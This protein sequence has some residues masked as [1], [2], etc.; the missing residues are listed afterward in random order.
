MKTILFIIFLIYSLIVLPQEISQQNIKIAA[1]NFYSFINKKKSSNIIFTKDNTYLNKHTFTIVVFED[2]N[3]IILSADKRSEPILA[4]SF[5]QN[6]TEDVPPA[7]KIILKEYDE[8]VYNQSIS[9]IKYNDNF[10]YWTDL[11]ENNLLKYNQKGVVVE[12]LI[13]TK[14]GQSKSN[15]EQDENAYNYYAPGGDECE[16]T[17]VGCPATS[18]GQIVEFWQHPNCPGFN[19][20][21]MPNKLMISNVNYPQNR[22]EVANLLRNIGHRMQEYNYPNQY[23]GCSASGTNG[24]MPIYNTVVNDFYYSDAVIY[25][26]NDYSRNEWKD[27]LIEELEE[28]RPI[29]FTGLSTTGGGHAFVCDGYSN[30]MIGKKFHFNFG[31]LG[32]YDGYYRINNAGG[33]SEDQAIIANIFPSNNCSSQFVIHDFYRYLFNG[34]YFY[35]PTFGQIYSSPH[36]ITIRNNEQVHYKAYNE[37][38]LENFETEEGA[39][40]TAEIIECPIICDFHNYTSYNYINLQYNSKL[41]SNNPTDRITIFPNPA[42]NVITIKS[43]EQIINIKIY[44][45]EGN[46]LKECASK[47][48]IDISF[49]AKGSYLIEIKTKGKVYRKVQIKN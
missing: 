16:H 14:W 25:E 33:Y 6:F 47:N 1:K 20:E 27:I 26:R 31:W 45:I 12:P 48:K 41:L 36:N 19:W 13:K 21:F 15:C 44:S 32:A 49:L 5:T 3:W 8:Y 38:I 4:Y 43:N 9:P 7:V 10:T 28:D 34:N 2:N 22:H 29:L 23:Y 35:N 24:I 30:P 40:F 17:L 11:I 39:E 42:E 46:L 37:I 18:F